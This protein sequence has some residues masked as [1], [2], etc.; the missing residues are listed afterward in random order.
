MVLSVDTLKTNDNTSSESGPLV[1]R[2]DPAKVAAN[3]FYLATDTGQLFISVRRDGVPPFWQDI[4]HIVSGGFTLFVDATNGND[5]NNGLVAFS[6]S[7]PHGV[8]PIRTLDEAQR[9]WPAF[10]AGGPAPVLRLTRGAYTL[11]DP[12]GVWT[13]SQ[14]INPNTAGE[15]EAWIG[16][17][18]AVGSLSGVINTVDDPSGKTIT[19]AGPLTPGALRGALVR[20]VSGSTSGNWGSIVSN[21]ATSIVILNSIG[22]IDIGSTFD[23]VRPNVDLVGVGFRGTAGVRFGV[24]SV[25]FQ[26]INFVGPVDL[27]A[28]S[29]RLDRCAV[30]TQGQILFLDERSRIDVGPLFNDEF[31]EPVFGAGIYVH[32]QDGSGNGGSVTVLHYSEF[33]FGS[34][35]S[36]DTLWISDTDSVV[37][38][39]SFDL[40]NSPMIATMGNIQ[41]FF[42]DIHDCASGFS[43]NTEGGPISVPAAISTA[44]TSAGYIGS[45]SVQAFGVTIENNPCGDAVL[46]QRNSTAEIT[47][48]VGVGNAGFGL[49]AA[50][51]G[52]I[53]YDS[54]TNV[55]GNSGLD[56]ELSLQNIEYTYVTVAAAPVPPA[57]YL[58][59]AN[60]VYYGALS[61]S[62]PRSN[63]LSLLP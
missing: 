53:L 44:I 35:V 12:A 61:I 10:R 6:P 1:L 23:V 40:K 4:S 19:V 36:D 22:H 49:H 43:Y 28:S 32:G 9:R 29:A 21:D 62:D 63:S 16:G 41:L 58:L 24:S 55:S 11:T 18:D 5:A 37:G 26:G 20:G 15:G 2:P 8:G 59:D 25:G 27:S 39:A 54:T 17:F 45:S 31:F 46:I 33:Q 3:V 50:D 14:G 47:S 7:N 38:M 56:G 52:K 13:V 30:D 34:V 51:G 42:G 57:A 48:V 60:G